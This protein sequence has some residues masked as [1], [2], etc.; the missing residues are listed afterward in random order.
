LQALFDPLLAST[1]LLLKHAH[2]LG[3][4]KKKRSDE[5]NPYPSIHSKYLIFKQKP[6]CKIKE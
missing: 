6:D 1:T 3:V 4:L 5:Q 2:T